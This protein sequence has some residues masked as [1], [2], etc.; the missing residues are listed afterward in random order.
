MQAI[1]PTSTAPFDTPRHRAAALIGIHLT[2]A[3]LLLLSGWSTPF[4]MD[5][6]SPLINFLTPIALGAVIA[7]IELIRLNP[8]TVA[9]AWALTVAID[10]GA[11][12]AIFPVI[13]ILPITIAILPVAILYTTA[14]AAAA[15]LPLCGIVAV[16]RRARG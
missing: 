7:V 10:L 11:A 12:I 6:D 15:A 14:V 8:K 3:T 13:A 1:Y 9:S 4:L 5:G 16:M 2:A